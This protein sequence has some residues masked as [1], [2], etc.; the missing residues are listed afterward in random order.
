MEID[1]SKFEEVLRELDR[2]R[3]L[4]SEMPT[5]KPEPP[6]PREILVHTKVDGSLIIADIACDRC[7]LFRE[8]L[9]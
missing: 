3:E 9:P 1:E 4:A 8:V 7:R 2:I 6:K 5:P